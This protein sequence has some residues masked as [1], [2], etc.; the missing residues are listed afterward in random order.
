MIVVHELPQ[1][2]NNA[3]F[4]L[5]SARRELIDYGQQHF[6]PQSMETSSLILQLLTTYSEDPNMPDQLKE[7]VKQSLKTYLKKMP[8]EE[9]LEGLSPQERLEG[10]PAQERV[11]GLSLQERLAGL[12]PEEIAELRTELNKRQNG[13]WDSH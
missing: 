7:F 13:K 6:R 1:H 2:E 11:K 8:F 4:H 10:I 9:R 5:F 3:M 12:S